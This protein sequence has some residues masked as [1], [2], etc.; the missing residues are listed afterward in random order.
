MNHIRPFSIYW[1]LL[2]ILLAWAFLMHGEI[3]GGIGYLG[4]MGREGSAYLQTLL[5]VAAILL[6]IQPNS[7]SPIARAIAG[8]ALTLSILFFFSVF[9]GSIQILSQLRV[10]LSPYVYPPLGLAIHAL[11]L[12]SAI[13]TCILQLT[14][15]D[16]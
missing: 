9:G 3:F 6:A 2:A 15:D 1:G 11:T 16:A 10:F 5:I 8:V 7:K 13:G 14:R 4:H 12:I